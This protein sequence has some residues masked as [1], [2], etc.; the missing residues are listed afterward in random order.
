MAVTLL[1]IS[2]GLISQRLVISWDVEAMQV[3][4]LHLGTG[5]DTGTFRVDTAKGK[6][7]VKLARTVSETGIAISLLLAARGIPAVAP[8]LSMAGNAW[9]AV[10]GY[11]MVVYPLV[12]GSPIRLEAM[13]E[14]DWRSVGTALRAVHESPPLPTLRE[15]SL[16]DQERFVP[17]G[18]D[19]LCSIGPAVSNLGLQ[20]DPFQLELASVWLQHGCFFVDFFSFVSEQGQRAIATAP[21]C[22]LCHGDF[23]AQNIL[24]SAPGVT[25]LIDWEAVVW[26]PPERDLIFIPSESRSHFERA[27]DRFT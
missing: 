17:W 21:A 16:P 12:D 5:I 24:R 20:V 4:E 11:Q 26:A 27:T 19:F 9:E 14:S 13:T 22:C 18:G 23:Q 8:V 2:R 25:H 15:L 10:A 1:P 7:F 6:Y 3:T